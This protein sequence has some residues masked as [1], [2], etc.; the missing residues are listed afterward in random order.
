MQISERGSDDDVDSGDVAKGGIEMVIGRVERLLAEEK[1]VEAATLL[2]TGA[3]GT[4]AEG[5][6]VEWAK[7]ARNRAIIE[8]GLQALKAH[9]VSV[10]SG[11]S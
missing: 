6:A 5:L 11:L 10:S 1:L 3:K 4:A 9:V 2:E 8:Q 7:Q